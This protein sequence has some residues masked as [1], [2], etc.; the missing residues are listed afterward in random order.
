MNKLWIYKTL[1]VLLIAFNGI[2]IWKLNSNHDLHHP[3][4]HKRP[5]ISQVLDF[6]GAAKKTV[7]SLEI[8]HFKEKDVLVAHLREKRKNLLRLLKSNNN[9]EIQEI[10]QDIASK[11]MKIDEMTFNYFHK[12]R[13][14]CNSPQQEKLDKLAERVLLPPKRLTPPLHR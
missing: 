12:I 11:N 9:F 7:D 8:Q 3:P 4:H 13:G 5:Q 1:I 10:L 2:L 6:K 14:L